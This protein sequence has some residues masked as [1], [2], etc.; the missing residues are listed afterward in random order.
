MKTK[1]R[2]TNNRGFTL[3]EILVSLGILTMVIGASIAS[4]IGTQQYS[5][6]VR[7]RLLAMNAAQS[8]IEAVKATPLSQVPNITASSF[9]PSALKNGSI[10]LNTSSAT[11]NLSVDSIATVTVIVSW[12]GPKNRPRT[13]QLT[14]MRSKY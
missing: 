14:T 13:F 5:E 11:G 2:K 9:V 12:T 8:V 3:M 10:A 6:D 7:G 4:L 1:K